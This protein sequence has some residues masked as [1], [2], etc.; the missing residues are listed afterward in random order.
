MGTASFAGATTANTVINSTISSVISLLSTS[1]TVT[2]NVTPTGSGAQTIGADTV[3]V[4]TNDPGGYTLTL[5][6]SSAQ[7]TLLSGSNTIPGSTGTVSTPVYQ[8]VNTWGYCV[9]D[10]AYSTGWTNSN[11][12]SGTTSNTAIS[13]T[14]KFAGVP[15]S[16]SP[17]TI[18]DYTGGTA[19][20]R[21]DTVYY[22]V[23]ANTSQPSGTYSNTVTYTATTN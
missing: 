22:A 19:T 11:C 17:A 12:P 10:S 23:A 1:G 3:T 8:A 15:A 5:A 9:Y 7:T 21:V 16:G 13:G 4:S 20:N 14:Y 6:S 2:V 18:V